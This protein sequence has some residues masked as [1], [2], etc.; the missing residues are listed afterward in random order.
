MTTLPTAT[1]PSIPVAPR[2]GMPAAAQ[3]QSMT[4]IDPIRLLK[5]YKWIFSGAAL[6]GLVLGVASHMVL[7]KTFPIYSPTIVYECLPL[8]G[9]PG[10][11]GARVGYEKEFEKFLATQVQ[12]LTSDRIIDKTVSDPAI[13][14]EAENWARPFLS[15]NAIDTVRA[16]KAL[17]RR[18]SA[19]VRGDSN[20]IQASFWGNND[21]EATAILRI[22]G[23]TYL[24]DRKLSGNIEIGNRRATL[25]N[26]IRET[27]VEIKR[28]QDRKTD[29]LQK[30]SV[31]SLQEQNQAA[32]KEVSVAISAL[33]NIRADLDSARVQLT[34]LERD[35]NHPGGLGIPDTIRKRVEDHPE[36]LRLKDEINRYGAELVAMLKRGITPN[37]KDYLRL[38]SVKEGLENTLEQKRQQLLHETFYSDIAALRRAVATLQQQEITFA[39]RLEAAKLRNVEL[40]QLL[41]QVEN[42][43]SEIEENTRQKGKLSLEMQNLNITTANNYEA[44]IQ[45]Y[46]DAQIPKAPTFPKLFLMVPLGVILVVGFVGSV[47]VLLEVIDQR[48]KGPADVGLIPR[49]RVLGL[50]PHSCEDPQACERIETVFRDR[51]NGVLAENFRQVRGQVMKRMTQGGH[52]TLLVL[53]PTPDSGTTAI[54]LNLAFASS[55]TDQRVLII[56]ANF[57][58]PTIHKTL[59]LSEGPG[60]ADC[61]AGSAT[62]AS[63]VQ[64]TSEGVAVL[65]VGSPGARVIERLA[66]EPM[67][68]LLRDA[69]A[70]Y[71]LVLVDVAPVLVAGD[72]LALANRCDATVMVVRAMVDKRGMV[73]RVRN[74]LSE[75]RADFLGVVINAA[76]TTA[77]GYLKG[78][79]QTTH[80]YQASGGAKA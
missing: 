77:G 42:L 43:T 56:D 17:K 3:A 2:P 60:L 64:T 66:T 79:I 1:R 58:R 65:A 72:A 33:A 39:N 37:H 10:E 34:E 21:R 53:A 52:K 67:S 49:T 14:R 7:M 46:Q 22:L 13:I 28:L 59:G 61:L 26:A 76:R 55:A 71:D 30:Q 12:V 44:R 80:R 57:R 35:M 25:S 75:T 8:Q 20:F 48:I 16:S 36:L 63:A 73:A 5:K 45:L 70:A 23:K 4:V 68:N 41:T 47:V 18:L 6:L 31:D 27:D 9:N 38:Q 69:A 29:M 74:E 40:T 11:P 32:N 78:N 54:T 62:L 15:N 51:P 50:I 19:G 24:E